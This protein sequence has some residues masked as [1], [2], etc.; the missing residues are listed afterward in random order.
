MEVD[1][2]ATI[3]M[4]PNLVRMMLC[5]MLRLHGYECSVDDVVF[6]VGKECVGVGPME[7]EEVVF[8]GCRAKNVKVK[9]GL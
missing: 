2:K 5:E 6:D 7:Y 4:N 3:E 1:V 8:K 9:K